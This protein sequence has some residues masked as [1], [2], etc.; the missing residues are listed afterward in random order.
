MGVAQGELYEIALIGNTISY[1]DELHLFL[2]PFRDTDYHVIYQRTIQPVIGLL[3]LGRYLVVAFIYRKVDFVVFY[4][5]N[6]RRINC[7]LQ[8][9]F[10]A[11]YAYDVTVQ[12]NCDSGRD[13][14]G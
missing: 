7:L 9:S 5:D 13:N 2:V 11:F 1:A 8:L 10:G 3:L 6:N 4:R 14:D 12:R